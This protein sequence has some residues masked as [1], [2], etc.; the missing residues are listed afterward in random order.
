MPDSI[1]RIED[2]GD[3]LAVVTK[4]W[5][6]LGDYR[7]TNS[8]TQEHEDLFVET[9][10]KDTVRVGTA[11]HPEGDQN[12]PQY[13]IHGAN[14]IYAE[15]PL[16]ERELTPSEVEWCEDTF[17]YGGNNLPETVFEF[18]IPHPEELRSAIF[19]QELDAFP[20]LS[21]RNPNHEVRHEQ[22]T[23]LQQGIEEERRRKTKLNWMKGYPTDLDPE[24]DP[25]NSHNDDRDADHLKDMA[26]MGCDA[27]LSDFKTVTGF[28]YYT[29]FYSKVRHLGIHEPQLESWD[30]VALEIAGAPDESY[31]RLCGGILPEDQFLHVQLRVKD[32]G[33]TMRVCDDCAENPHEKRFDEEGV[34]EAKDRRAQEL[35]GQR[36][37]SGDYIDH[38]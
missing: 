10:Q 21:T 16:I 7:S 2:R 28:G 9:I 26:M 38:E 13:K 11:A 37:L 18:E 32:E 34:S 15:V 17:M 22:L 27:H 33:R 36:R 29:Y 1:F 35:G 14:G 23:E 6:D 3:R 12:V 30:L 5:M 19:E 8:L 24:W 20:E 4:Q 25:E 31:C